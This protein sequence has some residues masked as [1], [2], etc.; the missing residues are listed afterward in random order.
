MGKEGSIS[1]KGLGTVA[2]LLPILNRDGEA[3]S[4]EDG[5]KREYKA[6]YKPLR[7]K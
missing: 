2:E 7:R 1:L 5:P 6:W 4:V 3:T